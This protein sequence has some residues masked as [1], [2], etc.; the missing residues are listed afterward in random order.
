[1]EYAVKQTLGQ[2]TYKLT[3]L[4]GMIFDKNLFAFPTDDPNNRNFIEHLVRHEA[5]RAPLPD[6]STVAPD[7]M[8]TRFTKDLWKLAQDGG[9]TLHDGNPSNAD[10][11]E[12]SKTLM[13]FAMQKYYEEAADSAGYKKELFT[14]LAVDGA[15]SNGIRFDMADVSTTFATAFLKGDALNLSDAKGFTLYF[16][17]DGHPNSPGYGHFKLPHLN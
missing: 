12:V 3:D 2:V 8:V 16:H 11:N 9:L 13:A 6:G 10:L 4:L 15:A 1:V 5:G 17:P 14:D 7:A